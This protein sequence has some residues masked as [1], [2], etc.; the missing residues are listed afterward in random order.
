MRACAAAMLR[1]DTLSLSCS[2]SFLPL[3]FS[4]CVLRSDTTIDKMKDRERSI[5]SGSVLAEIETA[6][7][8]CAGRVM[9]FFLFLKQLRGREM[10]KEG[11][12]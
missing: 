7:Y 11:C 2:L 1:N 4:T 9:F 3:S 6:V 8:V 12:G 5:G 10:E